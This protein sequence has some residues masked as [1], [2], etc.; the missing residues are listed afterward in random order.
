MTENK[1]R[2]KGGSAI[3][4]GISKLAVLIADKFK[5]GFIG[6]VFGGYT[7][8]NKAMK[9]SFTASVLGRKSKL[10]SFVGKIK[11]LIGEQFESSKLL[12]AWKKFLRF[13]IG[14][15][16]RFYGTFFAAFGIFLGL[17]YCLKRFFLEVAYPGNNY[18]ILSIIFIAVSVPLLLS[19]QTLAAKLISSKAGYFIVVDVLGIPE[20]KMKV[21]KPKKSDSYNIALLSA[22]A[23][24]VFSFFFNP[25]YLILGICTFFGT[26]LIIK[27]PEIGVLAAIAFLPFVGLTGADTALSVL[28]LLYTIGYFIK[29]IRGKRVFRFEIIDLFILFFAIITVVSYGRFPKEALPVLNYILGAFVA[30]NLMK[31]KQWQARCVT[32]TMV[33]STLVSMIIVFKKTISVAGFAELNTFFDKIVFFDGSAIVTSYLMIGLLLFV[34]RYY[35]NKGSKVRLISFISA[36][37]IVSA[38]IIQNSIYSWICVAFALLMFFFIKTPKTLSAV[39]L[40]GTVVPCAV[41]YTYTFLP[42]RW[43][44]VFSFT[45]EAVYDTL[46]TWQGAMQL[47]VATG[48][49]G[50]GAHGFEKYY[51][52]YAMPGFENKSTSSSLWLGLVSDLGIIGSVI[53]LGII[54]IFIQNCFEYILKSKGK[55]NVFVISCFSVTL[56]LLLQALSCDLFADRSFF[57]A[58]WCFITVTCATIRNERQE[59]ENKTNYDVNTECTASIDL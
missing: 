20:E 52:L 18:I 3:L 12:F 40:V 14:C 28:I 35:D 37:F 45:S 34:A 57:F 56:G 59:T 10:S 42:S 51:P 47:L 53:F 25:G 30:G 9:R 39:L 26:L 44:N 8:E 27:Y 41:A 43:I 22:I 13:F 6:R 46:K 32:A 36:L 48:F 7:K 15:Q 23:A 49:S 17:T 21:A 58:F 2:K 16:L 55:A 4:R 38:I 50:V 54:F 33:S 29:L 5:T 19:G 1:K 31:T 11:L 24:A